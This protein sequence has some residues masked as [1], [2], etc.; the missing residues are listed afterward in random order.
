LDDTANM[1]WAV[2]RVIIGNIKLED[3]S[4]ALKKRLPNLD[5]EI[6]RQ[7]A[8][9]IALRRFYPIR[10]F[11]EGAEVLIKNLGG[12][13]PEGVELYSA[14]YNLLASERV[15]EQTSE[16][17]KRLSTFDSRP[18][19]NDEV[20]YIN[21]GKLFEKYPDIKNQFITS[22]PIN[23][24]G[25]EGSI[26]ATLPNWLEDYREEMGV[27]PHSSMERAEYLFKSENAKKLDES[28]RKILSATLKAY[29]QGGELP[30]GASSG[31]LVLSE[32]FHQAT[33]IPH[34]TETEPTQKQPSNIVDLRREA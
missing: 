18:A 12:K 34:R 28:E 22:S 17:N 16:E 33:Q 8:L 21:I 7:I 6:F 30:V 3:F 9:D 32:L 15:S 20:V 27:P 14:K 13:A 10:D 25:K 1:V 23:L 5:D 31:K 11:L 29:D 26:N 24:K 4:E 2:S 19:T